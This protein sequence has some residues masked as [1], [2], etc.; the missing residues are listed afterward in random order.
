MI[1]KRIDRAPGNDNYRALALYIADAGL[2]KTQGEKTLFSWYS[3]GAADTESYW[4]GLEDVELVQTMNQRTKASKTYHLMVSF[5]PEDEAKL[6]QEVLR[7]VEAMLAAALGFDEHQRHAGVHQNT[8]NLHVHI[9]FNM[10]HP[11]T[12]NRHAPYRDHYKLSRA[13]REIEQ[14]FGLT[15]DKGAEPDAPKLEGQANSKIKAIE[16]QT[17][18]ESLFSYALRHKADI[19]GKL[20][21]AQSWSEVHAAFLQFG[22]SLA[23]SGNGLTIKDRHGKHHVKPSD[24]D[25]RL[26]KGQLVNRFG[27]FVGASPD[28]VN[29]IKT[30]ETYSG[31]PLQVGADR[32]GL[33]ASFK[34]DIE[35]RRQTLAEINA[36]SRHLYNE[37][38]GKW[39]KKR[40]AIQK[41]P[42]LRHDRERLQQEIKTRERTELD[43]LRA[44]TAKKRETI[45]AEVP[46]TS[47]N[48]CLQHK[49]AQGN[50]TALAILRS[51]N[52]LVTPEIA[53][54]ASPAPPGQ[55]PDSIEALK[56]KIRDGHGV[57]SKHRRALLSV[58]KMME[59]A[60][61]ASLSDKTFKYSIDGK[62]TIIYTLPDGGKIRDSG[63][64]VHHSHNSLQAKDFA[65]KYAGL[66]WGAQRVAVRGSVI[67]AA[68]PS[69]NL[70]KNIE[71]ESDSYGR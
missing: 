57:S 11:Q 24:I 4:Q 17:G 67:S 13:C 70:S 68:I 12:F 3:G 26:S 50:E 62:G 38:K 65:V 35:R 51:K 41:T 15:V 54:P 29:S 33:Y 36:E 49:A 63:K 31:N 25:R 53:I 16:A 14:K 2:G 59:V 56:L 20:E 1:P 39:A 47:W 60:E 8:N 69:R 22:L 44:D 40:L 23:P 34:E 32:A 58:L 43:Q 42:L 19:M 21:A 61:G 55:L 7:E 37:C 10:I 30:I 27:P 52:E 48:K 6:T 64:E 46:Y 18:Q 66:K 9:A 28:F 45:R 71:I 5:R